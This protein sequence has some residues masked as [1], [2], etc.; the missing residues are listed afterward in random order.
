M[1]FY[2][3]P[4][5]YIEERK[6]FPT[7][8]NPG[9]TGS[10]AVFS[11]YFPRG[12]LRKAVMVSSFAEFLKIF[13]DPKN[14]SSFGAGIDTVYNLYLYFINGGG[15]AWVARLG[16]GGVKASANINLGSDQDNYIVQVKAKNEGTWGNDLYV[17]FRVSNVNYGDATRKY[18]DIV[19]QKSQ[20]DTT[21]LESFTGVSFYP[22]EVE[23]SYSYA[24][25]NNISNYIEFTLP[26]NPDPNNITAQTASGSLSGGTNPTNDNLTSNLLSS[27]FDTVDDILIFI[28]PEY[29]SNFGTVANYVISRKFA[30]GIV[31]VSGSV[32]ET[33]TPDYLSDKI[34]VYYPKGYVYSPFTGALTPTAVSLAGAIAGKYIY[35]DTIYNVGRV[36]AGLGIGGLNGVA[37]L[38]ELNLTEAAMGDLY[39]RGFNAIIH[40]P[41]EGIIIWGARTLSNNAAERYINRRRLLDFVEKNIKDSLR[42]VNFENNNPQTRFRVTM[43]IDNF[44]RT[45]FNQG[46]FAGESPSEAYF[47]ICDSTNNPPEIV[48]AGYL[49]VNVG[50]AINKPAEFVVLV[51]QEKTLS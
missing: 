4:G 18:Y 33:F 42:W 11:N 21:V 39:N 20:T 14:P 26:S 45:L 2:N 24:A 8:I 25:I 1:P 44:L 31:N 22:D 13:A 12:P 40:R 32:I 16:S 17:V 49:V 48:D 23:Q 5:I 51:F 10:L 28:A 29:E 30:F 34:A 7:T 47:V 41:A 38:E 43:Q 50:I 27:I 35:T 46:Y 19:V 6:T 36:P 3:F 9:R 15:T 37:K